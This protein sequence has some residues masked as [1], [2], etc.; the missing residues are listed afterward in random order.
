MEILGSNNTEKET[1]DIIKLLIERG[2]N[3]NLKNTKFCF[4]FL[5]VTA[6]SI[7]MKLLIFSALRD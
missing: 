5:R 1:K 2:T 4:S 7:C 3:L 6:E